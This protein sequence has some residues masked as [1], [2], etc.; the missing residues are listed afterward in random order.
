[1]KQIQTIVNTI[2]ACSLIFLLFTTG[3][4]N[5]NAHA[6]TPTPLPQSTEQP[7]Q[8]VCDSSRTIQVSGTAVV[9]V[10][11]DRALI[12][13]GVQSNGRSAKE[14]QAKNAA[15]I[16]D[17]I[18][19]LKALGIEA[20][21]ISTDW[22]VIEPLYQDYDSLI[23][24]GYRIYNIIE[25]TVRDVD[26]ANDA[27]VAAMQAGANQVVNVE[28]YTSELRKYRDQAREM[29]M[30]A[31]SEKAKALAQTAGADTGCVLAINENTSSHFNGWG[32]WWWG[33]GNNQNQ[34]TQNVVQ[35]AAPTDGETPA[36]D[37]G[38]VSVGQ[39]SIRAE[40]GVTFGLK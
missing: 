20:K 13:L 14:A 8:P 36:L 21:D 22:Y 5:F 40:V 19:A 29:A 39:I 1:M 28:F 12:Q 35:N 33:Y 3:L 2:L 25:V 23:I 26:K 6:A 4:P 24:K 18:K 7:S 32:W 15:G 9:N 16:N 38:P 27:I 31:A 34:W 10:K 11:P 17:V 37:D 30:K